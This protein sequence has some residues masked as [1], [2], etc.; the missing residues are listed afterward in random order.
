MS[1]A[2]NRVESIDLTVHQA[3]VRLI[4]ELRLTAECH[5]ADGEHEDAA[6]VRAFLKALCGTDRPVNPLDKNSA[7]VQA[8]AAELLRIGGAG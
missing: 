4:S 7:A 8:V 5:D 1:H 6:A 3:A 2:A